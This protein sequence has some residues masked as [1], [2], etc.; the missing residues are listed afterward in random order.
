LLVV[1]GAVD[2]AV[3]DVGNILLFIAPGFFARVAYAAR[4]PQPK[5]QDLHVAV[6]SLA[7]SVPIVAIGSHFA[8]VWGWPRE[9][10]D[11]RYVLLLVAMGVVAG[12]LVAWVRGA[13]FSRLALRKLSIPFS[14]EATVY[15]QTV[16]KLPNSSEDG[17]VTVTFK[18]GR[19]VA[20]YVTIGPGIQEEG[21]PREVY[22]SRPS[23]LHDDNRWSDPEA[24][25]AAKGLIVNLEEVL[26]VSL[27]YDPM[28]PENQRPLWPGF[29]EFWQL[30]KDGH[31]F[32]P[33]SVPPGD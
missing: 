13:N 29:K 11:A 1:Q 26:T 19:A 27:A 3:N 7:A 30:L 31:D 32:F 25:D 23:W 17:L 18:D 24:P 4:F 8:H 21:V 12:Y 9:A 28:D 33:P 5:E 14:P 2:V 10:T 16:L 6:V 22:L 15:E 20:G